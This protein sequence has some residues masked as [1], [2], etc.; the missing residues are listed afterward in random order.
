[1]DPETES[2]ERLATTPRSALA[3]RTVRKDGSDD[4]SQSGASQR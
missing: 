1:M 4:G 3:T 2:S